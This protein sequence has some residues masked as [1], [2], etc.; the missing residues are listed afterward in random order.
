MDAMEFVDL[1]TGRIRSAD[2][3][4]ATIKAVADKM[5]TLEQKHCVREGKYIGNRA[6]G[7][8]LYMGEMIDEWDALADRHGETTI[9]L[10]GL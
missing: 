1:E 4:E 5:L 3:M 8:S 7:L 10:A 6:A 2:E 9:R